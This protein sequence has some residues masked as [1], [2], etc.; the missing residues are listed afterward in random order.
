MTPSSL[1]RRWF[2]FSLRTFF[3]AVTIFGVWLA[4][5]VKWIRDRHEAAKDRPELYVDCIS[6]GPAPATPPW[7][8]RL[9]GAPGYGWVYVHVADEAH[10][11]EDDRRREQ[12]ARS[13]FP[14]AEIVIV[15]TEELSL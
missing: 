9:L 1:P 7:S 3:V 10:L 4:V 8:L 13:L 14:E 11:S 12:L 2:R 15:H 6:V 5:Q